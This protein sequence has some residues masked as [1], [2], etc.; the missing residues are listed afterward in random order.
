MR[1]TVPFSVFP[2]STLAFGVS[3]NSAGMM[4]MSSSRATAIAPPTLV[5]R[6]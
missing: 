1:V 3:N 5:C 2:W 4:T 6:N